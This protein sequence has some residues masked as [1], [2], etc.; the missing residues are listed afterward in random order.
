MPNQKEK[1]KTYRLGYD[2]VFFPKPKEAFVYKGDTIGAMS[3][4]VMFQI[5]DENGKEEL[6][7]SKDLSDQRL[8]MKDGI[9]TFYLSNLLSCSFNRETILHIEED[10]SL[11]EKSGYKVQWK[12]DSYVKHLDKGILDF[13]EI[14]EEEFMD[15]MR[16]HKDLFDNIDNYPAQTVSYITQEVIL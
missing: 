5:F 7:E 11:I 15:I 3:I 6:F 9:S 2:Y 10:I 8:L 4:Y 12:I 1:M 14:S 16:N 13:M